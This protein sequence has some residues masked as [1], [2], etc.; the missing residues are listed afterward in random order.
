MGM[1]KFDGI[2]VAEA[3]ADVV[4][5]CPHCGETLGTIWIKTKGMGIVEQ[6]QI[7]LCPHCHAFLG[8]GTFSVG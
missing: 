5:K 7:I 8:Y 1:T 6:K 2:K 3:P 4:P